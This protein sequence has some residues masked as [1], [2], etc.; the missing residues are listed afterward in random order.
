M[1]RKGTKSVDLVISDD[2]DG[3]EIDGN[4]E[5]DMSVRKVT[6]MTEEVLDLNSDKPKN[7]VGSYHQ[8]ENVCHGP[9]GYDLQCT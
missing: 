3:E 2:D 4:D 9:F 8:L 5:I 1:S 6:D 7:P